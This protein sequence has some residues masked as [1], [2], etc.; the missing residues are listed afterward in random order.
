MKSMGDRFWFEFAR[1]STVPPRLQVHFSMNFVAY[2]YK[3]LTIFTLKCRAVLE[4]YREGLKVKILNKV[5]IRLVVRKQVQFL[6]SQER[7]YTKISNFE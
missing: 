4:I 2:K 5:A 6:G 7:K 1:E 3:I